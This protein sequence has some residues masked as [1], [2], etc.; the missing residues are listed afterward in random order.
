MAGREKM[1][2]TPYFRAY[3]YRLTLLCGYT[4]IMD[5]R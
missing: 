4:I 5:W 3:K 2:I 1:Q